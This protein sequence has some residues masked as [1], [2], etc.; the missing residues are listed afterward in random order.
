MEAL[1]LPILVG[2]GCRIIKFKGSVRADCPVRTGL[3][4]LGYH[5][6]GTLDPKY[7]RTLWDVDGDIVLKGKAGIGKGSRIS[8]SGELVLGDGFEVTGGCTIIC[9]HRIDIGSG[10]LFSWDTLIMDT[11]FH[12]VFDEDGNILNPDRPITIGD[13]VW[14]GCRTTVLKGSAIPDD[15]VIAA[16]STITR[17]LPAPHCIYGG[18]QGG[19]L[20]KENIH[21][22]EAEDN[23]QKER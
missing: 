16:G 17:V 10:C 2:R 8:V 13:R 4:R 15:S 11:D 22:G 20:F 21:W 23:L 19:T 12:S 5:R 3:L 1:R 7:E 9:K 18:T 6:L 14:I